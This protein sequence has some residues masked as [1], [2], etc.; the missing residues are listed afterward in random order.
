MHLLKGLIA[1][2]WV[3]QA[4]AVAIGPTT[5]L[6]IG[7]QVIAPDG[8]RR[9]AVLAGAS[10]STLSFPGPVIRATKGDTLQVNVIDQ[11]TDTSMLTG[12]SI[13]WHGIHQKGTSWADGV[14]GVTQCPIAPGKSFLYKFPTAEQA[15]TFWYHSHYSTQYCDGLRGALIVYDPEDP[16]RTWYDIDDESTVITLADWYHKVAH[17]EPIPTEA[18]A[19]LINGKGRYPGGPASPLSTVIEAD[20][21]SVQ[22]LTVNEITIYAGQ[23]YS[24]V[25]YANNPVGNYWIRAL[26]DEDGPSKDLF[27]NGIN[28]AILRYSGA[29]AVDPTT[30]KASPANPLVEANL[31]PLYNP[32]APGVPSPGKADV[33][34]KIGI[35]FNN[36]TSKFFVNNA[37]FTEVKVPVLLQILS[38]KYQPNQLLPAGSVYTLPPNKVIEIS[39]PGGSTGSPHPMHLHG[40]RY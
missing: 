14:V 6:V 30:Q 3:L 2:G 39:M 28:S 15:G 32:A 16:Y 19:T 13:H 29:P 20:S 17:L 31:R 1:L 34:L 37:T 36:T 27:K 10:A 35:T 12:T 25:L 8:L 23:R 33:N 7:N 40:V 9:S 5:N 4:Y 24:F 11:L 18:D 22:P 26:P 38:K 21:Q